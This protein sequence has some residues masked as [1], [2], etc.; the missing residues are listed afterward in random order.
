MTELRNAV[1]S[2]YS[3]GY[4][5][6]NNYSGTISLPDST[7]P[8]SMEKV[9]DLKSTDVGYDASKTY[10][11]NPSFPLMDAAQANFIYQAENNVLA[12]RFSSPSSPNYKKKWDVCAR[13]F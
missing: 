1:D 8:Y 2:N 4:I 13:I 5:T 7:R 9:S 6:R 10:I 11:F 12:N 3:S